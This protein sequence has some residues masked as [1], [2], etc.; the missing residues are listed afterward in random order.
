M[1]KLRN[2]I[3]LL[4]V[5]LLVLAAASF[6]QAQATR[7]WVSGVGDDVNPCSRTAPCK[8]FAGAISKTATCGEISVLDPGGFGAVT[9]TKSITINGEG[10]LAGILAALTNGVIVNAPAAGSA[11]YLKNL[12]IDGACNGINGIRFL[13]GTTLIVEKCRIWGFTNFGIDVNKT[14]AGFVSVTHSNISNCIAGGIVS[15]T[16]AGTVRADID[17]TKVFGCTNGYKA[18][19]NSQFTIKDSTASGCGTAGFLASGSTA[20]VNMDSCVA[21]HNGNGVRVESSGVARLGASTV[22]NNITKGLDNGGGTIESYSDNYIR[23]N[24][25]S[26][27]PS[28]VGKT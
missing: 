9:I 7:T 4:T 28:G 1:N 20:V 25:G 23:G 16:S 14:A 27:A 18:G 22:S 24:P 5:C 8:T 3:Q 21:T 12:D 11:I 19:T 26:D 2:S 15:T 17:N 13:A 10:T 6:A